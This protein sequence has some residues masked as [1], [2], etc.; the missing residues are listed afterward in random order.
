MSAV[1]LPLWPTLF[2]LPLGVCFYYFVL[3]GGRTF[4]IDPDD[5]LGSGIA[6][7]SFLSGTLATLFLGYRASVSP[8][9]A[10]AGAALMIGALSLYE[11]AR[12]TIR[13]R[14]F[15]I[16]WNGDV[17][18]EVC[19]S[20]PYAYVR[21]PIYAGYILAFTA[22]LAALP[23]PWTLAIFLLNAALFVHAA[24]DDERSMAAS[25]LSADYARYKLRTGM[26]FPRL[27]RQVAG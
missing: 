3:A 1:G 5:D 26:F 27:P 21:H 9:N 18:D 20:G 13:G 23:S 8:W 10:A 15:H 17:P 22:M 4:E 12:H 2:V 25:D 24:F 11:W 19:E 7:A 14:R 6:Q 16:A